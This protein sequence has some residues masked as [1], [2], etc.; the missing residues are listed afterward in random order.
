MRDLLSLISSR[1]FPLKINN[2]FTKKIVEFKFYSPTIIPMPDL[3]KMFPFLAILS[4]ILL[5]FG[6][7]RSFVSRFFSLF[8]IRV[9][10][11]DDTSIAFNY[12]VQQKGKHYAF[13]VH[14]Y[15]SVEDFSIVDK[16]RVVIGYEEI[17][18]QPQM[19]KIDGSIIFAM[20][21][22]GNDA[23][24]AWSD[25]KTVFYYLR[26]TFKHEQC[27]IRALDL[28]NQRQE[29]R[30]FKVIIRHGSG[31]KNFISNRSG[32]P[33]EIGSK[34]ARKTHLDTSDV[35]KGNRLLKYKPDQ[36]GSMDA[37]E[38]LD[39]GY[40]FCSRGKK[41]LSE[42]KR[43]FDSESWYRKHGILWRRGT[44]IHGIPGAGKTSL[45]RKICQ[46]LD[47][48]LYQF[49]LSSMSNSEFG[50]AWKECQSNTPCAV[51][52]DDI[53][54]VFDKQTNIMDENGGGLSFDALLSALSGAQ[55]AEGVL[56]FATANDINKVDE[57]LANVKSNT[58]SRPGRIDSIIEIG[59]MEEA[60]RRVLAE[61]LLDGHGL[62]VESAVK[63]GEGMTA[64]QFNNYLTD[65]ALDKYW[66]QKKEKDLTAG[67]S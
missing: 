33:T 46:I 22:K 62:D 63:T 56:V 25:N 47:M 24:G 9:E 66:S 59:V 58:A 50:E 7:I 65:I 40:V 64:A 42:C 37:I 36:L 8:V 39:N 60:N 49:D 15:N 57:T 53:D 13:G 32:E 61:Q 45:V 41:L 43:W 26:G 1:S 16:K 54:K 10:L 5:F 48:P 44:M 20:D 29:T 14:R 17:S 35:Y 34:G 31:N 19:I 52:F 67:E 2:L 30:R 3:I 51:L 38:T 18:K 28:L 12:Y 55:P 6:Q 11:L 23:G 27:I 4:P 21:K